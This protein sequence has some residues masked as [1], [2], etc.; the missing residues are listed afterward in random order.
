M[1]LPESLTKRSKDLGVL[2]LMTAGLSNKEIAKS[3]GFTEATI[4][5]QASAI[6]AKLGERDRVRAVLR[7]LEI[8]C[9]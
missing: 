7:G 2:A 6:F 5:T 9:I 3:Q 8:G 4:K 1:E